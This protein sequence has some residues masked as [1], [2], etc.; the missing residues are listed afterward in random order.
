MVTGFLRDTVLLLSCNALRADGTSHRTLLVLHLEE[1][2][3]SHVL[4]KMGRVSEEAPCE[5][6]SHELIEEAQHH[7]VDIQCVGHLKVLAQLAIFH[8]VVEELAHLHAN[9]VEDVL[10][11]L[12]VQKQL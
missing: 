12:L 2:N 1:E 6:L 5:V 9:L 3:V 8:L 11:L 4:C 7:D 10:S